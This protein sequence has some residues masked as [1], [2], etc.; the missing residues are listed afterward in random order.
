MNR[1]KI[2]NKEWLLTERQ[3]MVFRSCRKNFATTNSVWLTKKPKLFGE[4]LVSGQKMV[5]FWFSLS[6]LVFFGLDS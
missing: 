3:N 1:A 2:L 4:V 5:F 6:F